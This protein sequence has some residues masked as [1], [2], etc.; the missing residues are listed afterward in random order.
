MQSV[1]LRLYRR[2]KPSV[3]RDD[4]SASLRAAE[5]SRS[6]DEMATECTIG[7]RISFLVRENWAETIELPQEREVK[8]EERTCDY[9]LCSSA[10]CLGSEPMRVPQNLRQADQSLERDVLKVTQRRLTSYAGLGARRLI[11]I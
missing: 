1:A 11:G 7:Q 4:I 6:G 3:D 10:L 9:D 8:S 5:S 2:T